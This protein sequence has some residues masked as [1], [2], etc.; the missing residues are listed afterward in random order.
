M[1]KITLIVALGLFINSPFTFAGEADVV[2]VD[3]QKSGNHTYHFSVTVLHADTGWEH[4]ANK[5]D[6]VGKDGTVYGTRILH[7][8]HVGEQPFT[9]SLSGV[10]IPDLIKTVTVQAHDSVHAYGGKVISLELPGQP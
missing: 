6:V 10:E 9:R 4:Y 5:W 8:P 1:K 3:V 7:H 2:K